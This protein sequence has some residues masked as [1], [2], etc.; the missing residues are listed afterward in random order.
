MARKS[1]VA[2]SLLPILAL[3]PITSATSLCRR[4]RLALCRLACLPL[5]LVLAAVLCRLLLG[6]LQD[7][8][9]PGVGLGLGAPG[10]GMSMSI[11]Q[12]EAHL[13][14][15]TAVLGSKDGPRV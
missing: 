14:C 9:R 6:L 15:I 10:S 7:G 2:A 11:T 8:H 3:A 13:P 4:C 1:R 12:P 5:L